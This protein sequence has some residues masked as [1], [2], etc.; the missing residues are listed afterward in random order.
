MKPTLALRW[1]LVAL[2][3]V[4]L[5]GWII[6]GTPLYARL[7]YLFAILL[8]GGA[9]WTVF[10]IRGIQVS[11]EARILR[12]SVG[13]V[14]EER[15]EVINTTWPGVLWLEVV[16][17]SSLPTI[18]GSTS[19]SRLLTRIS[20][21]QRRFY[22]TR[23]LLTSRGSFPLGPTDA[24]TGD[25][26]GLFSAQ[27]T[28]PAEETLVVLPLTVPIATFP[29]P[30]GILAGGKN[31]HRKTMD[32]TPHA[33]GVRE[34]VP[35]DPMKRIHWPTTAHRGRF[36]V[37]EFEQDPQSDIW[38]FLD[39]Q[40]DVHVLSGGEETRVDD[41]NWWLRRV[42]VS[43]PKDTFEYAVSATASLA[44]F[45]LNEKRA[46][47]L[48]CAA[49]KLS[50]LSAERGE[51]QVGKLLETLAYLQPQG[52]LP[53]L[54][55]VTMQAK[56]LPLGSG[57]ILVTPSV[58]PELLLAV[59]DLQRRNLRPVVLLIRADTFGGGEESE[60]MITGLVNR[61]IPVCR[62]GFGDDLSVQLAL[63]AVYYQKNYRSGMSYFFRA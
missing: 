17:R 40:R 23:T 30:P 41:E 49:G 27:K 20:P 56:Q 26:L 3:A 46:V 48:A 45:F 58:K 16:N 6:S 2:M 31:I 43:L 62:I 55:L 60:T 50:V 5:A 24:R 57:V 12:A 7:F 53:I 11:R 9:I 14:F 61:D 47:G 44:R 4:G 39:A 33:A 8:V 63:P 32:V 59:E 34:Y 18:S 29:P 1:V 21:H 13:E 51:R 35:G 38:F 25:P 15:F 42:K 37:K 54:G 10:S 36:M 22:T 19:G 52:T 28:V